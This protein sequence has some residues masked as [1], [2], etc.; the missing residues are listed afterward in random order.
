MKRILFFNPYTPWTPHLMWEATMAYALRQRGHKVRFV[1]CSGLP[2]CGMTPARGAADRSCCQDCRNISSTIATKLRHNVEFM[3]SG[4]SERQQAE[5]RDWVESLTAAEL[6]AATRCG[7]PLGAWVWPDMITYWHT[8]EPQL[9]RPDV[10]RSYRDLIY[11]AAV[12]QA[13]LPTLYDRFQPDVVVTLNGAFFV[14]R[15]AFELARQRGLRTVTHERAWRDNTVMFRANGLIGDLEW[16]Q[17]WWK[18]WQ[19]TPLTSSELAEVHNLLCQRRGGR[20]MN[21]SAFSVAPQESAAARAALELPEGRPLA[22]LCTSSDCEGSIAGRPVGL[23]QWEWIEATVEWFARNPQ[24]TL[25][26]RVHPNELA[27]AEFDAR[28]LKRYQGLKKTAPSNV[29]VVLPDERVS[30]YT[31]MDMASAGLS[32]GS[33]AGLEMAALGLPTVH[34]GVGM[35]RDCEFMAEIWNRDEVSKVMERT[36]SEA[37]SLETRRM[38]Y[39]YLHLMYIRLCVP[40][41]AV[42]VSADYY[43]ALPTYESVAE[44]APGRDPYLDAI[45]EYLLGESDLYPPPTPSQRARTATEED[46]FFSNLPY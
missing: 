23:T 1:T 15:I 31:L 26:V 37:R 10:E 35:Y 8:T 20:N 9:E 40:F 6:P 32:Y 42:R 46:L 39:R 28:A 30:T 27:H 34:A 21:W 19:D 17:Q 36:M 38:A 13:A 25:V 3:Q 43:N 22:L 45:A 4:I 29:R 41:P 33:T 24:A 16:Y 5:L 14:Q 12:A 7:M 44:L 18:E 2:D 11:G